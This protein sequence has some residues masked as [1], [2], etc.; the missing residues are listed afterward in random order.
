MG[1]AKLQRVQLSINK[2][3]FPLVNIT[4][5]AKGRAEALTTV[6]RVVSGAGMCASIKEKQGQKY[7]NCETGERKMKRRHS[8]K[9]K[10]KFLGEKNLSMIMSDKGMHEGYS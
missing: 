3:N 8:K 10:E 6:C 4:R 2:E 5:E 9:F 7:S 1:S